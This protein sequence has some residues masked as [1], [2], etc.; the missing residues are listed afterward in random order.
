[1]EV[2]PTSLTTT[3][4]PYSNAIY[5]RPTPVAIYRINPPVTVLNLYLVSALYL[6]STIYKNKA[7]TDTL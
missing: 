5:K 7:T 1:M 3:L 2:T 6:V 4:S